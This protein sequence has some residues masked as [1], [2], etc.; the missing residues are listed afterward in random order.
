MS[1]LP[2]RFPPMVLRDNSLA[3]LQQAINDIANEFSFVTAAINYP[4]NGVT[5]ARPTM[6]LQV[7]DQFFD[8]T[9][10]K[11]IWWNGAHWVDATGTQV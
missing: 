10:G 9:L 7:G 1:K 4:S 2:L 5:S 8:K 11:P 6:Q 3:T